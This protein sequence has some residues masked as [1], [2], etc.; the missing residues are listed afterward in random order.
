MTLEMKVRVARQMLSVGN[1]AAAAA[2]A[3][4]W[5]RATLYRH[6]KQHGTEPPPA[7]GAVVTRRPRG[8]SRYGQS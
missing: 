2:E 4:G 3:V 8:R 6:L 5:S 7:E 1:G